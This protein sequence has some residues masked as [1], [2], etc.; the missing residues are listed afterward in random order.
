MDILD[1]TYRK[2]RNDRRKVWT[3]YTFLVW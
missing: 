1:K 3:I 2:E